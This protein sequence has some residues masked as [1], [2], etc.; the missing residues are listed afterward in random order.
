MKV[1]HWTELPGNKYLKKLEPAMLKNRCFVEQTIRQVGMKR[2]EAPEKVKVH[3]D[4]DY[5]ATKLSIDLIEP[6]KISELDQLIE[7]VT[8]VWNVNN[9]TNLD[10]ENYKAG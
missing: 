6:L 10:Y 4:Q 2:S 5:V 7:L 8:N 9:N 1:L 3:Y